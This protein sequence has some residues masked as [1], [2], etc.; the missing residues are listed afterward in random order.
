[1]FAKKGQCGAVY[2]SSQD[3]KILVNA[4]QRDGVAYGVAYRFLPVWVTQDDLT[5]SAAIAAAREKLATER[6]ADASRAEADQKLLAAAK[7]SDRETVREAQQAQLQKQYQSSATAFQNQLG[8]QLKAFVSSDDDTSFSAWYPD[9]A[10]VYAKLTNNKWEFVSI[11]TQLSD[12]GT[13]DFKGRT[14]EAALAR[15]VIKMKNAPLGEYRSL[16]F[17]TGY[18]K[19]AEFGVPRDPIGVECDGSDEELRQYK[20]GERFNSRWL[21]N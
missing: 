12:Y 18:V 5:R 20:L 3:L 8:D 4:F 9:L 16:C 2:A 14:L 1:V 6:A 19:D 10:R 13:A 17:I 15:S 11:D 7:Q 21:V